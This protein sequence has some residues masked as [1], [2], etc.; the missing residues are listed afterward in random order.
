[1]QVIYNMTDVESIG[2]CD[3][4]ERERSSQDFSLTLTGP[5]LTSQV[6]SSHAVMPY[7]C[8]I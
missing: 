5:L 3:L 8:F 2:L 4:L 6:P 7:S 1:M